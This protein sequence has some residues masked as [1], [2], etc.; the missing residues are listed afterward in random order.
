MRI[1]GEYRHIPTLTEAIEVIEKHKTVKKK[2]L[3]LILIQDSKVD[4][5]NLCCTPEC[6]NIEYADIKNPAALFNK[7]KELN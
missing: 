4:L 3:M 1:W 6:I 5:K 7:L 2:L